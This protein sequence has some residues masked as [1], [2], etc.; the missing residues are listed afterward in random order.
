MNNHLSIEYYSLLYRLYN[1]GVETVAEFLNRNFREWEISRGRRQ[2]VTSFARYLGV[3]QPTLNRWMTGDNPPTGDNVHKLAA[4]L[5]Y[6][7]Y[8]IVGGEPPSPI[9]ETLRAAQDYYDALP[10]EAQAAYLERINQI[11]QDTYSEFGGKRL[12]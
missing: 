10:P 5:G 7:I 4:K 6:E 12:K 1:I 11:I 9:L 3:K 8:D 2:T